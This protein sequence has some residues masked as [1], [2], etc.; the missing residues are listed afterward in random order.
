ML[1]ACRQA[2]LSALET[3]Y[4]GVGTATQLGAW[5]GIQ[6]SPI[7][8]PSNDA[9]SCC[10]R[11]A[12]KNSILPVRAALQSYLALPSAGPLK[13]TAAWKAFTAQHAPRQADPRY[14]GTWER[15]IEGLRKAGMS[16][17]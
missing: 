17:T 12:G 7:F 14:V 2:G 10:P 3:H 15:I 5:S 13:T 1:V 9:R 4:A 11:L 8:A 6:P 16:E